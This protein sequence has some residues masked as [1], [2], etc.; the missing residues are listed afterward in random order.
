M[1]CIEN[2]DPAGW[3]YYVLDFINDPANRRQMYKQMLK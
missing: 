2:G 1:F 3:K